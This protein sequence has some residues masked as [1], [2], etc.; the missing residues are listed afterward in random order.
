M[1]FIYCETLIFTLESNNLEVF[2]WRVIERGES[3]TRLSAIGCASRSIIVTGSACRATATRR[4]AR[5]NGSRDFAYAS[6]DEPDSGKSVNIQYLCR[7]IEPQTAF[8]YMGA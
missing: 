3:P 4:A 7:N 5:V 1:L 8:D 2:I 6:L